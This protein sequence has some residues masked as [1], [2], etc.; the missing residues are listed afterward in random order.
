MADGLS[1]R[2]LTSHDNDE[3]KDKADKDAKESDA[4]IESHVPTGK[5]TNRALSD[6]Q[7]EALNAGRKRRHTQMRDKDKKDDVISGNPT[8]KLDTQKKDDIEKDEV[9]L[10]PASE[11]KSEKRLHELQQRIIELERKRHKDKLKKR[12]KEEIKKSMFE[13]GKGPLND[14]KVMREKK[15]EDKYRK[16]QNVPNEAREQTERNDYVSNRRLWDHQGLVSGCF[17]C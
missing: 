4:P 15:D 3:I 10:T 8:D 1:E 9:I 16:D 11:L 6:K 2:Q 17:G 13:Q 14:A 12:I 7:K 5:K